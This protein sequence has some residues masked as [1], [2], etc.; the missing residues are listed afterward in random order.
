MT[1]PTLVQYSGTTYNSTGTKSTATLTWQAGDL[2]VVIALSEEGGFPVANPT[3]TGLTFAAGTPP[4]SSNSQCY[5]NSWTA[6]AGSGGSAV[7]TSTGATGSDHWGMSAWV[8]RGSSGFGNTATSASTSETVSL[9][10]TGTNSVVVGGVAD[11]NATATTGYGWTPTVGNDRTEGKDGTRYSYYVADWGDQGAAG[12]TSYGITGITGGPYAIVMVEVTGSAAVTPSGS[13]PNGLVRH[14]R[15]PPAR[16]VWAG[17]KVRTTNLLS[18]NPPGGLI[19]HKRRA[20]ARALVRGLA[21]PFPPPSGRTPPRPVVSHRIPAR[22]VWSGTKVRT[23]NAQPTPVSGSAPLHPVVA[24]RSAARATWRGGPV[25]VPV[26][27]PANRRLAVPRRSASRAIWLGTITRTTNTVTSGV[28]GKVPTLPVAPRRRPPRAVWRGFASVAV[29]AVVEVTSQIS[30]R[31]RPAPARAAWR[32]T[33]VRTVNAAAT[34]AGGT[35]PPHLAIPRRAA[36]RAIWHGTA[37]VPA[38]LLSR[39][40]PG[41]LVVHRRPVGGLWGGAGVAGSNATS[42]SGIVPPRPVVARRAAARAVWAGTTVRTVNT[43]PSVRGTAPD[44]LVVARR[45]GARA[46]WRGT[47]PV[48]SN[49][50]P[51]VPAPAQRLVVLRRAAARAVVHGGPVP[52]QHPAPA[53]GGLVRRRG[54]ARGQWH[55]GAGQ[56]RPAASVPASGKSVTRR[57]PARGQWR[58]RQGPGNAHGPAVAA[59]RQRPRVTSRTSSRGAWPHP[60]TVRAIRIRSAGAPP[61]LQIERADPLVLSFASGQPFQIEVVQGTGGP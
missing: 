53:T 18:G 35:V 54:P 48:T 36:A 9:T 28:P 19:R 20:P 49:G 17:T 6:T 59:P 44:R 24:R 14:K 25:V 61:V 2:I 13:P 58:G 37:P 12:T 55:G 4:S 22:A 15:R 26:P 38:R 11:W 51:A 1:A 27:A 31:S 43:V 60:A 39:N 50:P 30:W 3:A 46:V 29:N 21:A 32:G 41:G 34:G 33:T 45:A 10:R 16:A 57:Q 5:A 42:L 8:W 23:T 40:L 52:G 7:V 47:A 56:A